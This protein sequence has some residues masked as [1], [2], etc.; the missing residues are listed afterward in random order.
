MPPRPWWVK[1][2]VAAACLLPTINETSSFA[3]GQAGP[4]GSGIQ[5]GRMEPAVRDR[6]QPIASS[7]TT[8]P[9]RNVQSATPNQGG[10]YSTASDATSHRT[11][12][13]PLQE[14]HRGAYY[15][16]VEA[17]YSQVQARAHADSVVQR[18]QQQQRALALQAPS[19]Q[20]RPYPA[21]AGGMA[22]PE[23]S[24]H[25]WRA[26]EQARVAQQQQAAVAE[27]N[28]RL[29]QALQQQRRA[30]QNRRG[31][32]DPNSDTG[33][34][35]AGARNSY[36]VTG[37]SGNVA[38]VAAS[39]QGMVARPDG[40]PGGA[41]VAQR[42]TGDQASSNLESGILTASAQ[43]ARMQ[44]AAE[45][46]DTGETAMADSL[47]LVT[48]SSSAASAPS[49][50]AGSPT[51]ESAGVVLESPPSM[52][53]VPR[54]L[55][56][57][58]R[59]V[60]ESSIELVGPQAASPNEDVGSPLVGSA[61]VPQVLQQGPSTQGSLPGS[62]PGSLAPAQSV[63]PASMAPGAPGIR[64]PRK[65]P[66]VTPQPLPPSN[67]GVEIELEGFT[68]PP[69]SESQVDQVAYQQTI[70]QS[71][72]NQEYSPQWSRAEGG[73][74][75]S[76]T[77]LGRE[78]G[79]SVLEAEGMETSG[80][81]G[82]PSVDGGGT[83][84]GGFA[85]EAI[86]PSRLSNGAALPAVEMEADVNQGWAERADTSPRLTAPVP[87]P[88]GIRVS[89]AGARRSRTLQDP[90][91]DLSTGT[92]QDLEDLPQP[93]LNDSQ[94]LMP[95]DSELVDSPFKSCT[96]L[97]KELLGASLR[98]ISLD[99]STPPSTLTNVD[100]PNAIR[101]WRDA[102]NE[103]I[104]RG[105]AL[106]AT[107]MSVLILDD[108]GTERSILL[109][110]L[111][112]RDQKYAWD[113]MDLPFECGLAGGVGYCRSFAPTYVSWHASNLCH[114][115]LYFED[116]QLERYGHTVGPIKQPVKSAARFL[117]Q[118]ALLPYQMSLHPANECQYP[119]GLFRPGN[120]APY[121]RTPFPWE[122]RALGYQIGA[123]SGLFLLV[124]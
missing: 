61:V 78:A 79:R 70:T 97:R 31:P 93:R 21:N 42:M 47:T 44:A 83:S 109:S 39:A 3:Q 11:P 69:A 60:L 107:P 23:I 106:S 28:A 80:L 66:D 122:R 114:K 68:T 108:S 43:M 113:V 54:S 115:P 6:S 30:L 90:A 41:S 40:R 120:C 34:A 94:T 22:T 10:Q 5:R 33:F 62:L 52:Q 96:D 124:P 82:P 92:A 85:V 35:Q 76:A 64:S 73:S 84:V 104:A 36:Q 12:L 55:P 58:A 91:L 111:S 7:R 101:F 9:R 38:R 72:A 19:Q 50:L 71:Y 26:M 37:N 87:P 102:N 100:V 75:G 1:L 13:T 77:D 112:A 117:I 15:Q 17:G 98:D 86:P 121:L 2:G 63:Q 45:R 74:A 18:Y 118:A 16:A 51:L 4:I 67:P 57:G 88:T 32:V 116:I 27:Q 20:G 59:S 53:P 46:I 119:L 29:W 49:R 89:P 65:L 123:T 105:R 14:L 95:D 8:A 25:Q 56:Q 99:L 110:D 24:N 81:T 48:P 103:V